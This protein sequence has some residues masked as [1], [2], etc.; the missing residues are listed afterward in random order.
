MN[1]SGGMGGAGGSGGFGGGTGGAG[2][3]SDADGNWSAGGTG[4]GGSGLG[5]A[6][7]VRSGLLQLIDTEFD[8]NVATGGIGGLSASNGMGKGGALFVCSPGLCGAGFEAVAIWSGKTSFIRNTA[9]DAGGEQSLPGRDDADVCGFLS[10]PVATRLS[11]LVPSEMAPGEAFPVT[12]SA[13]DANGN[14]VQS[15]TGV[16]HLTSSDRTAV[17]PPDAALS[18]GVATLSLTMNSMGTQTVTAI[19][20]EA[21]AVKGMSN[22][23]SVRPI[24]PRP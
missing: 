1:T 14:L 17:L 18:G 21:Q 5:G 20:T 22:P 8:G 19:V 4:S 7:F 9:P 23:I 12:V 3:F 11:V 6:I 24:E 2:G 16:V 10:S 13:L 15:Y